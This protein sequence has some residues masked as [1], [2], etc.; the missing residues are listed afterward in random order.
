[1][2]S[3]TIWDWK[4]RG[5]ILPGS[6]SP[7]E[8]RGADG[9]MVARVTPDL[10]TRGEDRDAGSRLMQNLRRTLAATRLTEWFARREDV[11]IR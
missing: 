6:R 2:A 4:H 7:S 3:V 10:A 1:M 8:G 11:T 9:W 5:G